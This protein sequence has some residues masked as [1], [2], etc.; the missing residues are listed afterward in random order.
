MNLTL[1]KIIRPFYVFIR[2]V[3]KLNIFKTIYLNFKTQPFSVAVKFPIY[4]YGKL[5]IHSLNGNIIIDAPII[6]GMIKIGYR[7]ID[8]L[9]ISFLPNQLLVNGKLIFTGYAV[10]SGGVSLSVNKGILKIGNCCSIGG[11][12]LI[13]C[14]TE[15]SIGDNTR[16]TYG[17]SIFD[18]NIHFVKEI[19]SGII[20]KNEA[21]IFIGKNCWINAE[22]FVAKGSVIPDFSI[23]A[24][25][26]FVNNDF[27]THGTN[28]FLVGSPAKP[29]NTKVQRIFNTVE[30][31]RI[32]TYF[33]QNPDQVI[34]NCNNGL[35]KDI[36]D[37]FSNL[38][39]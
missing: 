28:L 36:N 30:E 3:F 12:S 10:L 5:Y 2:L 20:K 11:G 35:Y 13:K 4:V 7:E 31:Q 32:R 6:S 18:S 19:E 24:R 23:T 14:L 29:L 16:I 37:L 34:F 1:K 15:I 27:N 17:C 8:S 9:P 33:N 38:S 39:Y 21:P 25:R 22:T 26:S